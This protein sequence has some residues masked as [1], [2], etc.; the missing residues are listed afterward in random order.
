[1]NLPLQQIANA[2]NALYSV[3][4]KYEETTADLDESGL[5]TIRDE[6]GTPI[7]MMALETYET[8]EREFG[9]R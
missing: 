3:T 5:V 1:M 9:S 2:R 4:P 8:L 7:A 6:A